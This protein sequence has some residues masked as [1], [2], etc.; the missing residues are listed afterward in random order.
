MK[1]DEYDKD[2]EELDSA[3]IFCNDY[4]ELSGNQI[5]T[6]INKFNNRVN[7][8]TSKLLSKIIFFS[9]KY[10]TIYRLPSDLYLLNQMS[11]M[12]YLKN[13]TV[14]IPFRRKSLKTLFNKFKFEESLIR[15][16]SPREVI[17]KE[18]L[19]GCMQELSLDH[20]K[21][22]HYNDFI[23]F[24]DLKSFKEFDFNEFV[25]L[26]SFSEIYFKELFFGKYKSH[27]ND[28]N[29]RIESAD[30]TYLFARSDTHL[31]NEH[32][33]KLLRYILDKKTKSH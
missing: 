22:N 4:T 13:F 31:I 10:L 9:E 11:P 2:G 33:L 24:L 26:V 17:Y 14:D 28:L 6:D 32:L 23:S 16:T 8:E 27:L 20:L 25:A 18:G 5:R 30:F 3:E 12:E 1:I 19:F 7:Q 15:K 21:K 29:F